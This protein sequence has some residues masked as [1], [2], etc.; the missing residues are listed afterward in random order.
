[1]RTN[2]IGVLSCLLKLSLE[3][4]G[5]QGCLQVIVLS[6]SSRVEACSAALLNGT[7]VTPGLAVH[8]LASDSRKLSESNIQ[9][10]FLDWILLARSKGI[11]TVGGAAQGGSSFLQ[12]ARSFRDATDARGWS[13][14]LPDTVAAPYHCPQV[15]MNRNKASV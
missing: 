9:K 4:S 12:T 3:D 8:P 5:K 1:M 14:D 7:L 2:P 6:D 11:M 13:V 15:P 10:I